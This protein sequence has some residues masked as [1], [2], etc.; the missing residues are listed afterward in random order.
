MGDVLQVMVNLVLVPGDIII[1][2]EV[3]C[4]HHYFLALCAQG[5]GTILVPCVS[6][7]SLEFVMKFAVRADLFSCPSVIS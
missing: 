1:A 7:Q 4:L 3:L 5:C 6:G 2:G